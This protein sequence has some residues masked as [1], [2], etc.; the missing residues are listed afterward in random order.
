MPKNTRSAAL[1]TCE[2]LTPAPPPSYRWPREINVG[3]SGAGGWEAD[4]LGAGTFL[5]S[6]ADAAAYRTVS[7][8]VFGQG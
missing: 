6:L 3:Y 4:F 5:W 7:P 8:E 1:G 2:A